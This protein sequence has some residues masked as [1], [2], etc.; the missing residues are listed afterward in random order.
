[1][2]LTAEPCALAYLPSGISTSRKV[3]LEAH[4]NPC[5]S[6]SFAVVYIYLHYYSR[7]APVVQGV[8]RHYQIL[9]LRINSTPRNNPEV[10]YM[11]R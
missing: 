3:T 9:S 1:M 10:T 4:S 8:R 7:L 5:K 2:L 11:Y 6:S